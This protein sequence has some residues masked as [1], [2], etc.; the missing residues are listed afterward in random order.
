MKAT[1]P[2]ASK[3]AKLAAMKAAKLAVMKAAKPA[4][5]KAAKLAA[6]KAITS[7]RRKNMIPNPKF[8]KIETSPALLEKF[9]NE[10]MLTPRLKIIDW[11]KITKQTPGLKIGYPA[12]H[13]ASL[14]T[15]VEGSRSAARGDDLAD[16][17]EVKGCN[18]ID[19]LD[20]CNACGTKVLRHELICSNSECK[21]TDIARKDDSKWLLTIKSK[22]IDR[23]ILILLDYPNFSDNDFETL[24][25]KAYEIW[26][27]HS[28]QFQQLLIDYYYD[29]YLKHIDLNPNKT[30]A[31]KN[32][33]PYSFQFY[34]CK[35]LKTYECLIK[36][37][38]TK[39]VIQTLTFVDPTSDRANIDPEPVPTDILSA[40]ELEIIFGVH[41][42]D[43]LKQKPEFMKLWSS[44]PSTKKKT[45]ESK[46][47]LYK[48]LPD[49]PNH[50][51][52][53]I[54]LRD[55]SKAAPHA[56]KYSRR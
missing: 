2:A 3:A 9:I 18:R 36:S 37:I 39:P 52:D 35:P 47:L 38:N 13:I 49:L 7:K 17:S 1:K 23:L 29:I 43:L 33:W 5:R 19:Q 41:K 56:T 50:Y 51:L 27:K 20:T 48:E 16:G 22:K 34:K 54:E 24:T 42:T 10:V 25:V 40:D 15:G 44:L 6:I 4:A 8:I 31:P 55:T 21:S 53:C 28:A 26:P 32:L 14:L 45:K 30:P 46:E 11:S 12:Q